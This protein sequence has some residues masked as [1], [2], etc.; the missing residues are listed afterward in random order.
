M[1]DQ[2]GKEYFN[3]TNGTFS[4]YHGPY[5]GNPT[6]GDYERFGVARYFHCDVQSSFSITY[7]IVVC[8]TE[9]ADHLD[10]YLNGQ[11]TVQT[12]LTRAKNGGIGTTISDDKL[13]NF[14]TPGGTCS[15]WEMINLGLYTTD[16]V[17]ADEVFLVNFVIILNYA[18]D[19]AGLTNI[20]ITCTTPE[21][22]TYPTSNP[23]EYLTL[24][25]TLSPTTSPTSSPTPEPIASP[26]AE[27]AE[28][29]RQ[30]CTDYNDG[31]FVCASAGAEKANGK[32]IY[33]CSHE[34]SDAIRGQCYYAKDH[35]DDPPY[36][37]FCAYYIDEEYAET[38]LNTTPSPTL[39]PTTTTTATPILTLSLNPTNAPTEPTAKPTIS[40]TTLPSESPTAPPTTMCTP[41]ESCSGCASQNSYK[42]TW[43]IWHSVHQ[44][45]YFL[46]L[47]L[48]IDIDDNITTDP[49]FC[50]D[51]VQT[52]ETGISTVWL[53]NGVI[54]TTFTAINAVA[55]IDAQCLRPNDYFKRLAL[56]NAMF[57]ILDVVS[58]VMFSLNVTAKYIG[59]YGVPLFIIIVCWATIVVPVLLSVAQLARQSRGAWLKEDVSREWMS[60]YSLILYILPF[61]CGSAFV[62]IAILN[63]NAFQL[64]VFSMG[65][66]MTEMSRFNV[67]R[68]W[69]IILLEVRTLYSVY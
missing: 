17:A 45:C 25:P 8:A 19:S 69:T 9:S 4:K 63:S 48:D 56:F 36:E 15:N 35:D 23:P 64:G 1:V 24:K 33:L 58:D 59:N 44:Q 65:L 66:P 39:R 53:T 18:P 62:A 61:C 54:I 34:G 14:N 29:C 40:P 13:L 28:S 5:Y 41:Y 21:P 30:R 31:D 12:N 38:S 11:L 47:H 6:G 52:A 46:P 2:N 67:Q 57:G 16:P 20:R 7:S 51:T 3:V 42:V 27:D 10:L 50:L 60:K 43:C 22:T 49:S 26:T 68:V 55:L 32:N 37:A